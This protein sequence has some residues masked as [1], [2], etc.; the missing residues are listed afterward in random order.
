[1]DRDWAPAR[2]ITPTGIRGTKEQEQRATSAL[3]SV[4][5]VV[6]SFGKSV[7]RYFGAP[8]GTISTY[9]EPRF[10][11]DAGGTAIPDGLV[12]VERGRT[13]WI[14]LVEVKTG[15]SELDAE[16]VDRYLQIAN[17]ERFDALLTVS[18]QIVASASDSPV[19]VDGRRTRT[20]KLRHLSWF[21]IMTEA[22]IEFEHKGIDDPEQAWVLGDL[23]AFL[24]DERS[25]AGGFEGMGRSWVSVR[26][27]AR[28]HTLTSSDPEVRHVAE[29]WEQFLEYLSLRLRQSVGRPVDPQYQ[30][31]S[32]QQSRTKAYIQELGSRGCMTGSV[33]ITDA[34]GPVEI[35]ANLAA[36]QVTTS[37][38][39][40]A[41]RDEKQRARTSVSW[42]LRQLKDAPPDT[43]VEAHFPH[44]RQPT[45]ALIADLRD[46][47]DLL[48]LADDKQRKPSAFVIALSR[49]MG[50]KR[51][52]MA[53]SFVASTMAQVS[54][55]Y[56]DVV[57]GISRW[58][59]KAP[60]LVESLEKE[61]DTRSVGP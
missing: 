37:V 48:L 47:P 13:R 52:R 3:L 46:R 50:L 39:V 12:V 61:D 44:V 35:D 31:G 36:R 59:P 10:E 18:N 56:R 19:K 2:L 29:H 38:R 17:R 7:L 24:D 34:V 41:P 14:A 21:R 1:M 8:A 49:D 51:G 4:M 26:D 28:K 11:T 58:Q 9:V 23:V 27:A 43:R 32:T 40:S 25:G 5:Q 60:K 20:V 42:M 16:Q 6:P 45:A 57:Q 55:F 15:A 33:K 22:V 30:R 53:G 54:D